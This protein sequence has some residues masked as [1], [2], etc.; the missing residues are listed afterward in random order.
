MNLSMIR[1][2][3]AYVRKRRKAPVKNQI[4]YRTPDFKDGSLGAK[5]S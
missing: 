4:N 1:M 5:T 2:V 3:L